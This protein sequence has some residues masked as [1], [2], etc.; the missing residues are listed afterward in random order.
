[1]EKSE[2]K[3]LMIGGACV[4]AGAVLVVA[5]VKG[6]KALAGFVVNK[7]SEK[8]NKKAQQK[9]QVQ[10]TTASATPVNQVPEEVKPETT[11]ETKTEP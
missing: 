11:A 7:V 5:T 6:A 9:Q 4:A 3:D 2:K 8:K 10:Q 1:M